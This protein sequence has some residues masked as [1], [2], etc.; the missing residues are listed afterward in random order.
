[1]LNRRH[2]VGRVHTVDDVTRW[3]RLRQTVCC[4]ARG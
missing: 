1:M 4:R 3:A 2:P